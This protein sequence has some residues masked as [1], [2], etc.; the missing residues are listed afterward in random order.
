MLD[1]KGRNRLP[2]K[3]LLLFDPYSDTSQEM[4]SE[5]FSEKHSLDEKLHKRVKEL[6]EG[7]AERVNRCVSSLAFTILNGVVVLLEI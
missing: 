4:L 2:M 1:N 5:L 6:L 3:E 7:E